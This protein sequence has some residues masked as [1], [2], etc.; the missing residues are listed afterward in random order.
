MQSKYWYPLAHVTYGKQEIASALESMENFET[1]MF[2]KTAQFEKLFA[3]YVGAKHAVMVNSGSSADLLIAYTL[4]DIVPTTEIIL[5][6]AITWPTQVWSL[7]MA[8]YKVH[9]LDVNSNSLNISLPSMTKAVKE[10]KVGGVFL[11]HLLGNTTQLDIVA[12]FCRDKDIQLVEDCC[13][14]LGTTWAG[15]HVGYHGLMSSYS[16]FFSHHITTME[17]GMVTTNVDAIADKL[18]LLRAHGWDRGVNRVSDIPFDK[19]FNFVDWGFN[20][21]PTELQAAFGI[22]QMGRLPGFTKRRKQLAERFYSHLEQHWHSIDIPGVNVNCSPSWL[23]LPIVMLNNS[24]TKRD[25]LANYLEEHGV[26]TRPLVSGNLARQP[27]IQKYSDRISWDALDGAD[28]L[29]RN[30]LYIGL[31][32]MVTDDMMDQLLDTIDGFW[33]K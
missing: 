22:E 16:F 21:R 4:L 28:F 19:K 26:E 15:K 3:E 5:V 9:L 13:E 24:M 29:H 14:A 30:G 25:K 20:V 12:D 33:G 27:A 32:P 8:G 23:G 11:T 18:R 10:Q 31:S 2:T 7:I 6:P 1:T 17:G